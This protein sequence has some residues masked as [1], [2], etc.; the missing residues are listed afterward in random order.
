MSGAERQA[1]YQRTS[2]GRAASRRRD[3][4]RR[5]DGTKYKE[6][7]AT[8]NARSRKFRA[9]QIIGVSARDKRIRASAKRIVVLSDIHIP[10]EDSDALNAA[11]N[12]TRAF[13]PDLIILNG[14]VLD[15]YALSSYT[16]DPE[17]AWATVAVERD[18]GLIVQRTCREITPNVIWLGGNHEVRW[19]KAISHE[20]EHPS[21]RGKAV[22]EVLAGGEIS[23]QRAFERFFVASGVTWKPY[24]WR[25][26]LA[27]GNLVVTHGFRLSAHSAYSA[28]MHLE[29]L[30]VSVI[31]GHTHRMGAYHNANLR[32]KQGAWEN[33]CLCDMNP[34]YMQFPNWQQGFSTVTVN[35]DR[36]HVTQVPI[37]GGKVVGGE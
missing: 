5:I 3:E 1:K 37:V 20:L 6:K 35:G 34:E 12:Y 26:E 14:D 17:N 16:K 30:G 7:A 36:F 31:I 10:F 24:G 23:P 32:G 8:N 11:I 27:N 9:A 19:D 21:P 13:K 28:R 15:C 22:L 33:G 2:K 25:V 4:K 29:R 18:R